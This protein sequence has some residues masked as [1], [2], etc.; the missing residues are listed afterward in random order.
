MVQEGITASG[1]LHLE[2]RHPGH[3][4]AIDDADPVPVPLQL[5]S[6]ARTALE[7]LIATCST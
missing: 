7:Q 4:V 1:E 6:A 5:T 2:Q 3:P